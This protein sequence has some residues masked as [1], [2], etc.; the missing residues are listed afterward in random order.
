LLL[1]VAGVIGIVCACNIDTAPAAVHNIGL[2]ENR[3]FWSEVSGVAVVAGA[4]LFGCGFLA[5][6]VL[7]LPEEARRLA[8]SERKE[9]MAITAPAPPEG[10]L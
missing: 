2:I 7:R 3:R 8:Q 10:R 9:R 1:A 5:K 4:V 6:A